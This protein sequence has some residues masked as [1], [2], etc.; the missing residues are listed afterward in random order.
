MSIVRWNPSREFD[1]FFN[2]FVDQ[3]FKGW[4]ENLA[5]SDWN[6]LSTFAKR[7][8][9]SRSIWKCRRRSRRTSK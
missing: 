7:T 1:E 4:G 6:P 5:S 9:T 8:R 2:R 3:G